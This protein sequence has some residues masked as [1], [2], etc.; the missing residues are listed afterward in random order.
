MEDKKLRLV[1]YGMVGFILLVSAYVFR[2]MF[3]ER[4]TYIFD[5]FFNDELLLPVCLF[6]NF[7]FLIFI[8]FC[9]I[10]VFLTVSGLS[11]K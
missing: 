11:E 10:S 7:M 1:M 4:Y 5:L 8:K 9:L 2:L 6:F 3:N